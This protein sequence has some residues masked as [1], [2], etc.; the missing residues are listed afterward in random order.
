MKIKLVVIDLDV[1]PWMKKWALRLAIPAVVLLGSGV[2]AWAAS[3]HTWS[4]GD[5]LNANDLN[6]NFT[7][8]QNAIEQMPTVTPWQAFTPTVSPGGAALT[9]ETSTGFWRR[10]GDTVEISIDT[11]FS[12]CSTAGSVRW[13]LPQGLAVDGSKLA[14]TNM[15]VGDG[16]LYGPAGAGIRGLFVIA[17]GASPFVIPDLTTGNGGG[18]KCTDIGTGNV[19]ARLMFNLPIQGW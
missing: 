4:T 7:S 6:G 19:E 11:M 15:L 12:A 13:S 17:Q 5:T 14:F 16:L 3:L 18:I 1:S 10:V 8:L 2:A 9:T